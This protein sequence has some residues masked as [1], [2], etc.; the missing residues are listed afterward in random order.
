MKK[1]IEKENGITLIALVVTIVVLLILAGVS[2]SMLTGENGIIKQAQDS[3]EET[4]GGAVEE[5]RDLW[6]A[7]KNTDKLA[8]TDNVQTLDEL[9][10]DLVKDKLL[11]EDEKE[12]I[13]ET[14]EITIGSRTIEFDLPKKLDIYPSARVNEKYNPS[15]EPI[16]VYEVN[17]PLEVFIEAKGWSVKELIQIKEILEN[18]SMEEIVNLPVEEKE[19]MLNDM[20]ILDAKIFGVEETIE[21]LI[22]EYGKGKYGLTEE[23][24]TWKELYNAYIKKYPEEQMSYDEFITDEIKWCFDDFERILEEYGT[25]YEQELSFE[26]I[27]TKPDGIEI[28]EEI[29]PNIYEQ[30]FVIKVPTEEFGEYKIT[31][32]SL[33]TEYEG[34]AK[35]EYTDNRYF[36][37]WEDG[38]AIALYDTQSKKLV[39]ID[40][41]YQ[42]LNGE[43]IDIKDEISG[44]PGRIW[45]WNLQGRGTPYEIEFVKEGEKIRIPVLIVN[46]EE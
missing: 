32:K 19:Q 1:R 30:C 6:R 2:I 23:C 13:K 40:E 34:T 33:E 4:R 26:Y 45:L 42:Y 28:K 25:I 46:K 8:N 17:V 35:I 37:T 18:F 10:D 44:T 12:E 7:D 39:E 15:Y 20:V 36:A 11:S 22:N 24:R 43:K 27:I 9:L 31:I 3:K 14:G 41:V 5:A 16:L 29:Q 21:N 38:L